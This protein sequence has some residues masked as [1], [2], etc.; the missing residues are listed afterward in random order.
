MSTKKG[1]KFISTDNELITIGKEINNIR[2]DKNISSYDLMFKGE[3]KVH[4]KSLQRL[5]KGESINLKTFLN[6]L[7]QLDIELILKTK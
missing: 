5:E 3:P 2:E 4:I 7:E 1:I 6:I